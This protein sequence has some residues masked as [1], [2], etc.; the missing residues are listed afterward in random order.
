MKKNKQ[1]FDKHLLAGELHFKV[2]EL[3]VFALL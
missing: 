3:E 2:V 1:A